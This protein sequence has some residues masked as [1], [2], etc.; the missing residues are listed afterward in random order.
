[1]K[2]HVLNPALIVSVHGNERGDLEIAT[3]DQ[4]SDGAPEDR[5][6]GLAYLIEALERLREAQ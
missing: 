6:K 1:M 3:R 5:A 4:S 2:N